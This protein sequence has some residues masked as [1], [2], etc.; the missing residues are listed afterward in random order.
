M[1]KI[2]L[3]EKEVG[4]LVLE[5]K[6][7]VDPSKKFISRCIDGR[8]QNDKT[9]AAQ[10]FPGADLGELA[11]ILATARSYGLEIDR[12]KA[13]KTLVETLGGEKN[14]SLHTD[15]HGDPKKPASGCGHFK[16]MGL[17][18]DAYGLEKE[19]IDFI[20]DKLGTAIK[21]GAK[22]TVLEGDHIEGAILL[23]KGDWGVMPRYILDTDQGTKQV[24]VF[25]YHQTLTDAKHRVLA[26]KLIK[27]KAIQFKLGEDAE[28]LYQVM[29]ETAENHLLET[30]KR[31][32]PDLPIY[33]LDFDA[34]GLFKIARV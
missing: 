19:D 33:S 16:Q 26:E 9:I 6:Y 4:D 12:E 28:Y 22:E 8:Y 25:V 21:K 24:E 18:P 15:H 5:N 31:L 27:N 32:A 13:Y 1:G 17:D 34:D 30:A 7:K 10:A 2:I 3:T 11:M 29:S 20:A 14:F 23:L